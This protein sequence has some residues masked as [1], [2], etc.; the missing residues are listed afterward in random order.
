[1]KENKDLSWFQVDNIV[2]IVLSF[3]M[4]AATFYGLSSRVAILETKMDLLIA[5][6]TKVLDNLNDLNKRVV[7]L[8]TLHRNELR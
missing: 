7:T 6:N 1:M 8:E 4:A 2:P 5:Q 3:L